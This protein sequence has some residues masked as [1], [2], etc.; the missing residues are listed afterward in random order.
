VKL[1]NKIRSG[2]TIDGPLVEMEIANIKAE[3]DHDQ[4]DVKDWKRQLPSNLRSCSDNVLRASMAYGNDP[5]KVETILEAKMNQN[6]SDENSGDTSLDKLT[7]PLTKLK[8]ELDK[9]PLN[10]LF[11]AVRRIN[12]GETDVSFVFKN[13][14]ND[15]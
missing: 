14:S 5:N 11:H 4:Y 8:K 6:N 1:R 2:E 7:G 10:N 15:D 13:S 12:D 3:E 9:N